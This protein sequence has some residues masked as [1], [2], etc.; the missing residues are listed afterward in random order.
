MVGQSDTSN[1]NQHALKK[2][3]T[4]EYSEGVFKL[5]HTNF[6]QPPHFAEAYYEEEDGIILLSALTD[7]GYKE[8]AKILHTHAI[9]LPVDPDIRLHMPMLMV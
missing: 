9:D 3:F 5:K 6:T 7:H 4:I 8:M 1:F 2:D